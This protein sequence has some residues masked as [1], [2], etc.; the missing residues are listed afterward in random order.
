VESYTTEIDKQKLIYLRVVKDY[1]KEKNKELRHKVMAAYL[2]HDEVNFMRP[3]ISKIEW[4]S[5]KALR[6]AEMHPDE[7]EALEGYFH[8]Y[9]KQVKEAV[10]TEPI[11]RHFVPEDD[12][13]HRELVLDMIETER[14]AA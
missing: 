1:M 4:V 3:D 5:K 10:F 14:L 7:I 11:D 2:E 12:Y 8:K 13:E 6:D 9:R